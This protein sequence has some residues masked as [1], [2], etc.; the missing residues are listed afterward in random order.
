MLLEA[1]DSCLKQSQKSLEIIVF[2]DGST[3][4]T[5]EL[6][7]TVTDERVRYFRS[8]KNVGGGRLFGLRH[9]RGKYIS[10]LDHDDYYTDYE[11][12]EKAI[13]IHE[14]HENDS[15]PLANV[16]ANA[17]L[18]DYRKDTPEQSDIGKPGR[19][20][21]VDFTLYPNVYKKPFSV[22]PVVY[23]AD[24][25][26][27]IDF[28]KYSMADIFLYMLAS[29]YGDS[30]FIPDVVGVYRVHGANETFG[31]KNNPEYDKRRRQ[32]GIISMRTFNF[33]KESLYKKADKDIVDRWYIDKMGVISWFSSLSNKGFMDLI[34]L[35]ILI[36]KESGFMPKL[37]LK[38]PE[39]FIKEFI[40]TAM[41]K[42]PPLYRFYRRVRWGIKD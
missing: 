24:I 4:G 32:G 34:R 13:K 2:D 29:L 7:K 16:C 5:D 18:V 17:L 27:K 33:I 12:F 6:M 20:K 1:I 23:R 31:V 36:L 3:D 15:Y 40:R 41:R 8:E 25:L 35:H 26:R 30:W 19:V 38:T 42:I 14:E 37:W 21:G 9:A 39:R 10:F 28:E 11:F 22:F